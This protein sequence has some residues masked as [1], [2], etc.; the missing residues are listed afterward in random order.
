MATKHRQEFGS[1]A[2]A[3]QLH[4]QVEGAPVIVSEL[5]IRTWFWSSHGSPRVSVTQTAAANWYLPGLPRLWRSAESVRAARMPHQGDKIREV[6]SSE[7]RQSAGISKSV[8]MP[9]DAWSISAG[10]RR[11]NVTGAIWFSK[12][13]MWTRVAIVAALNQRAVLV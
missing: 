1:G 11:L 13:I 10:N 5:F 2:A 12:R 8:T 6:H 7:K 9:T 4:D 3:S